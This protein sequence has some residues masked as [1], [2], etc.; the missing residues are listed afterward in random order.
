L[1]WG[2]RIGQLNA[3]GKKIRWYHTL[4]PEDRVI[5][6]NQSSKKP[7]LFLHQMGGKKQGLADR[8]FP[9]ME[10]RSQK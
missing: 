3:W 10:H 2:G 6:M 9:D 1:E 8:A 4:V 5:G 7:F